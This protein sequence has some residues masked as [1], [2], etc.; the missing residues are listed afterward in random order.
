MI[1]N[2]THLY[3]LSA[4]LFFE[5]FELFIKFDLRLGKFLLKAEINMRSHVK[6]RKVHL[7]SENSLFNIIIPVLIESGCKLQW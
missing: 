5:I 1:V 2:M 6:L 4:R 7:F 3:I